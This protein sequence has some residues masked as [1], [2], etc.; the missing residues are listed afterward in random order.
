MTTPAGWS[1]STFLVRTVEDPDGKE[2]DCYVCPQAPG[3]CVNRRDD[4]WVVSHV[5]SG[6]FIQ[7]AFV[8]IAD[9]CSFAVA[10]A[11]ITDWGRKGRDLITDPAVRGR[12]VLE[13]E[14]SSFRATGIFLDK[15]QTLDAALDT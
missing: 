12:V 7:P 15:V 13:R 4:L 9:A 6:T 8:R 11:P 1:S 5:R 14:R 2:R 10:I 3:L